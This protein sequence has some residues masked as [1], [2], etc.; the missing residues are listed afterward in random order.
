M[1]T[2]L[3]LNNK[4][5]TDTDTDTEPDF[6]YAQPDGNSFG[7]GFDSQAEF[8]EAGEEE[9][10]PP[11]SQVEDDDEA[12]APSLNLSQ[13]AGY[14]ISSEVQTLPA[15]ALLDD[16]SDELPDAGKAAVIASGEEDDE[17]DIV[18]PR[19]VKT[20]HGI[21]G[22]PF[23]KL[24][25]VGSGTLVVIL[26]LG[27]FLSSVMGGKDAKAPLVVTSP[28]LVAETVTA[29]SQADEVAKYKTQS[30]LT[31]QK[32]LLNGASSPKP[33]PTTQPSPAAPQRVSEAPAPIPL[34]SPMPMPAAPE[35]FVMSSPVP[36]PSPIATP[37][38]P[39]EKWRMAATM[40]S[41]GNVPPGSATGGSSFNNAPVSAPA[42]APLASVLPA[43]TPSPAATGG[44]RPLSQ[45]RAS[46]STPGLR[47]RPLSAVLVGTT[48]LAQT[49]TGVVMTGDNT[50]PVS[51]DSPSAIKYLVQL[52]SG[53]N[54]A[55]GAVA[56]PA[57]STLVMVP[58]SFSP[59]NGLAEFVV[60]SV[61]VD[62]KEYT[63]PKD[64]LV[65][66]GSDG[67]LVAFGKR[68]SGGGSLI[69]SILPSFFAGVSQAGQILNQP[70]SSAT[71]SGGNVSATTTSSKASPL[72]GFAQ[73]FGS[74]LAQSLQQKAQAANQAAANAPASWQLGAGTEVKVFVNA[75]FEM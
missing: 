71:V 60:S 27:A 61:L 66:R 43:A 44:A 30:A 65:V 21:I 35:A 4:H 24:A 22:S 11:V 36:A 39:M 49:T 74:N 54:D 59:Q 33:L 5:A 13:L 34:A 16:D 48:A 67:G 38:D 75:S 3:E 25:V 42:S 29:D 23:T 18:D 20:K 31:R 68:N 8:D 32:E 10:P 53:L 12:F 14:D 6:E 45:L 58:R 9:L 28:S 2:L 37:V 64:T 41:Y 17:E 63:V 19:A 15:S 70:S 57:G 55:N 72:A 52:K 40:G 56:I 47:D 26:M 46:S 73:G 62:N 7:N 50:T 51:P 69:K 1:T